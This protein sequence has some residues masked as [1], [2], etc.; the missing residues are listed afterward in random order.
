MSLFNELKRR[1]VFK[2]GTAY[3]VLSWIM[4]QVVATAVPALHLPDWVNSLVFLLGVVGF[5]FAIFFA[6]AFEITP[7]GVKKESEIKSDHSITSQTGRKLDFSIIGLL[8]IALSYFVWHS[9]VK[10]SD[11]QNLAINN[12]VVENKQ[13]QTQES[14]NKAR[15]LTNNVSDKSVAVL[16]FTNMASDNKNE[17]F[18]LGIHDDLLTHLSKISEL[19]VISRTSVLR[20]K[21]TEKPIAEI[22]QELGVKNILEGSV[23]TS[24]HQIR[25]NVQLI[26]AETDE[27][28]WAEIYDRKLTTENIFNIQT[29]ISTKI[30]AALKAQLSPEE[31]NSLQKKATNNLEAYNAYIAGRQ[32]MISRTSADLK[33]ALALFERATELDPNY[34]LAYVGQA[35]TLNLLNEYSDLSQKEMFARGEQLITKALQIEPQLAEAHTSKANYLMYKNQ[36]I[37]AEKSFKYSLTLNPNYATTYHWYGLLLRDLGHYQQFL[38]IERKAAA[39][40]PLSPVIQ[41]N[42][43]YALL[44]LDRPE[45]ALAQYHRIIVFSPKFPGAYSGIAGLQ[46]QQTNLGEGLYWLNKAVALDKGNVLNRLFQGVTYL[47]IDD[48][49]MAN[50]VLSE[51]KKYFPNNTKTIALQILI[52]LTNGEFNKSYTSATKTQQL[53]PTN[54]QQKKLLAL[55]ANLEGNYKQARNLILDVYAKKNDDSITV[56][57]ENFDDML[58]LAVSYKMLDQKNEYRS[59]LI[60]LKQTLITMPEK[61]IKWRRVFI[62]AVQEHNKAAAA[63][64]AKM[65]ESK[66]FG[67]WWINEQLLSDD[68]KKQTEYIKAHQKLMDILNEQREILAK[69]ESAEKAL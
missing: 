45:E 9:I 46:I 47:E 1:N 40:D 12:K 18:A 20:F 13:L 17:S 5:P 41:I 57:E 67:Q 11:A 32:H 14:K 42:V 69:L 50:A 4:I 2:V 31:K 49:K 24:G 16:P 7:D 30:A 28:L 58:S 8:V 53:Q 62:E 33:Q 23:Q 25:I 38:D 43:A 60:Q 10:D 48:I 65:I 59:L 15:D 66:D 54:V 19:K 21:G 26:D 68:V 64:Y 39:L 56:D 22:A 27:H 51:M 52:Y 34:A 61:D 29:E 63:A 37:E 35:D 36:N 44:Y 3:L 6:W 55:V